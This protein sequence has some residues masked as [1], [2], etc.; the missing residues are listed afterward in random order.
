MNPTLTTAVRDQLADRRQRLRAAVDRAPD[1]GDLV[2]LLR[3]VDHALSRLEGGSFGECEVCR[4]E[5]D[6]DFLQAN[7]LIQ[8]C[9][10]SLSPQ[11]QAAL[12]RDLGLAARIQWALLP[13]QDLAWA[14]WATH[15]RYQPAG[16]VSGDYCDLLPRS[17]G[18]DEIFFALGDVSGKGVAASLLMSHLNATF[19][20]LARVGLGVA[21]L[22]S[23]ANEVL[24][25]STIRSHYATL[26]C[27]RADAHGQIE[28]ANAGHCLPMLLRDGRVSP[29][30]C[31]ETGGPPVGIFS[32][33]AYGVGRVRL[34]P[35][36]TLFLYTDGVTEAQA[37]DDREYGI[38]RL[39]STLARH[40]GERPDR[41]AAEV[42][43]DLEGF[44][45]A[46]PPSD[47]ASLLV[48]RR[49]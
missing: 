46:T 47:D 31:Q 11:Q 22:V 9:L 8:Y 13:P 32:G 49:S 42:L 1:A 2:L 34:E 7:P 17:N 43:R 48:L 5:V 37:A 38:E 35:G 25:S 33:H 39:T 40:P 10:C 24:A 26:V 14:G 12:E 29:L 16:P 36:D 18:T 45:G 23:Q 28:I 20:S 15:F 4:E 30:E 6:D 19:R 27:G 41:L 44:R 21:E 3:E